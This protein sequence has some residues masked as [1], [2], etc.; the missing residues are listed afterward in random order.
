MTISDR[1]LD[2]WQAG[3]PIA[4]A[5][6]PLRRVV[7]RPAP[8]PKVEQPTSEFMSVHEIA[9]VLGV[10]PMTVY[11]AIDSKRLKAHRILR[12]YRVHRN[13]FEDWLDETAT[14]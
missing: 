12:S 2:R 3:Q 4:A 5:R 7:P 1:D 11:R 8:A 13:D 10:S 6:Q 9:A 14:T